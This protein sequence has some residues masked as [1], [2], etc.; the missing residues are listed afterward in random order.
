[1]FADVLLNEELFL[2]L[3]LLGDHLM[4]FFFVAKHILLIADLVLLQ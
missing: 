1:M 3:L 2:H 4:V